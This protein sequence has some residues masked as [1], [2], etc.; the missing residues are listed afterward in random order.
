MTN[1]PTIRQRG[2]ALT[3]AI[4]LLL[5]LTLAIFV[6]MP[7]I[8]G[9]QRVSG[10]DV[11]A[12]IAQHV[13]EAGL[14]HGREFLR[15]NSTLIPDPLVATDATKWVVCGA[16]DTT[17]P[18]GTI[19]SDVANSALR[20][21]HYRYIGG[22]DGRTVTFSPG[23]MYDGTGNDAGNFN[24]SYD[25]GVLLCRLNT[26]SDCTLTAASTT[27]TSMFTLV[28]RGTVTDEGTT[29]TVSETIGTFRLINLS[30]NIPPV[31][32]AGTITGLGSATVVGNPGVAPPK[33]L[34]IWARNNF[35]GS[36]GSWQTCQQD[37]YFRS[38][39]TGVVMMGKNKNVPTCDDCACNVG[40]RVSSASTGEGEDVLDST[41]TDGGKAFAGSPYYYPCDMF[42]Y[43]LGVKARNDTDADGVC[44]T[45]KLDDGVPTEADVVEWLT[46][47]AEI[48]ACGDL[49]ADSAGVIWV[50]GPCTGGNALTGQIGSPDN[51]VVLVIDGSLKLNTNVKFFG[52]IF[53]R[54]TGTDFTACVADGTGCPELEPGGG[55]AK[56]YGSLV[57]EGGGKINGTVD[58]IYLPQLVSA[59]N[60]SPG[61]NRFAGLPG[62]WS[63]RVAY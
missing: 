57:M 46:A 5:L 7:A 51:P 27:A 22:S 26:T 62:S 2:S 44:E 36:G 41:N 1:A 25:V 42:E 20:A 50:Q 30:T 9:E 23:R 11:R 24:A 52:L 21:R 4:V 29:A 34:A 13:A 31:M 35:D 45:L 3:V 53:L 17:F 58:I 55:G 56:V 10:N 48:K 16:A 37:E 19:E 47:N 43:V 32:A 54:Y 28:A 14:S 6:A 33:G 39:I 8:L 49:N 40:Q 12:K 15:L 63:D 60:E 61:N 18:C 38:D 59:F